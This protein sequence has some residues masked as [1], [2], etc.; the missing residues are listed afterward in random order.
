MARLLVPNAGWGAYQFA[1]NLKKR[2][3]SLN[4]PSQI[5]NRKRSCSL[6]CEKIP[7]VQRGDNL[8]AC[9]QFFEIVA[10]AQ[11]LIVENALPESRS[12]VA[13]FRCVKEIRREK[14]ELIFSTHHAMQRDLTEDSTVPSL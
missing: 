13:K 14:H 10:I 4:R 3:T 8:A 5:Q 9:E 11:F 12:D 2:K 6:G 1:E 7:A